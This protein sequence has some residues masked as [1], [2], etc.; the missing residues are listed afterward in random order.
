LILVG[1]RANKASSLTANVHIWLS[2]QGHFLTVNAV[3][4]RASSR[5]QVALCSLS[6]MQRMDAGD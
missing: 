6:L 1:K 3:A 2:L 4:S 5:T